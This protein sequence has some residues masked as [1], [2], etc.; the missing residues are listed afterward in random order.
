MEKEK[1][2][3][4]DASTGEQTIELREPEV[5]VEIPVEI[6]VEPTLEERLEAIEALLLEGVLSND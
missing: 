5:M 3:I 6:N 2:M 4:L 1:V